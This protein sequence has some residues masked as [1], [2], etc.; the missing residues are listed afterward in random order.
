MKKQFLFIGLALIFSASITISAM[1]QSNK[2]E[3]ELYQSLFGIEKKAV[4]ADFL[5]LETTDPF[6]ALYD[7]YETERKALGKSRVDLMTSYAEGYDKMDD[8][9]YDELIKNMISLRKDTDKLIETYYAKVKK[10]NGSKVAAQFFQIEVYF[11]SAIRNS[12]MEQIP[13]I[14]QFDNK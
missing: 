5:K 3:I 2:E 14:G 6:W 13:Y 4:V 8:K 1:A 12:I 7:E 11:V 10:S 9:A